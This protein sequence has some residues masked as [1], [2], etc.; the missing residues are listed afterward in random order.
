MQTERGEISLLRIPSVLEG[1]DKIQ[2]AQTV[3]ARWNPNWVSLRFVGTGFVPRGIMWGEEKWLAALVRPY[4]SH[5][6][7]HE[8]WFDY[9]AGDPLKYFVL[10]N[11]SASRYCIFFQD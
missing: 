2:V 10:G 7:M 4:P 3:L 11:F 8:L 9:H 5:L 6:M 1:K